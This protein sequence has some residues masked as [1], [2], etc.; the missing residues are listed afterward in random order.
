M[1][2][3]FFSVSITNKP[4]TRKNTH[5]KWSRQLVARPQP[6]AFP[7]FHFHMLPWYLTLHYKH[8]F[9]VITWIIY[10]KD[11]NRVEVNDYRHNHLYALPWWKLE[12]RSAFR[13]SYPRRLVCPVHLL[14]Y[15][16]DTIK[17]CRHNDLKSSDFFP[18]FMPFT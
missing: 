8:Y 2:H 10:N 12:V 17:H 18:D 7:A 4:N 3:P 13:Q 14:K 16:K 9:V 11:M 5:L 1:S 6:K 15:T